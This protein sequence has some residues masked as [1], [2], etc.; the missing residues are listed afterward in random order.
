MQSQ[1]PFAHQPPPPASDGWPAAPAARKGRALAAWLVIVVVCLLTMA[2]HV[3]GPSLVDSADED[4]IG[5][6]IMRMQARYVVGL[7]NSSIFP[8]DGASI[9][10]STRFVLNTGTVGQRQRSVIIAADLAGAAEAREELEALDVLLAAPP[11]GGPVQLTRE[12]VSVQ[13]ILHQLYPDPDGVA[14]AD[15][16]LARSAEMLGPADRA[17]L[18]DELGWFG[19]LA[20]AP[21]GSSDAAAREAVLRPARIVAVVMVSVAVLGVGAVGVGFIGLVLLVVFTLTG[22]LRSGF[23]SPRPHHAVYAETF[24]VWMVLFLGLQLLAKWIATPGTEMSVTVVVF[25]VSLTALIWPVARGIPWPQ[26][27]EDVGWTLG[28]LPWAEPF[29]GVGGYVVS[30]PLVATGLGMTLLLMWM[31]GAVAGEQPTFAPSG[32]PAHPIIV[33]MGGAAVW[34]KIQLLFLAAIV[35]PIVEE[36]MFRGVLYRHLR[37]ASARLGLVASVLVSVV[38]NGFVFAAIHPQGLV[39][40]PALMSLACGMALIREWRGT[41]IPAVVIHGVS[42]GLIMG[43]LMVILS[44]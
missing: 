10:S 16:A 12:Q 25:L 17:L 19:E 36:T 35:A 32:G 14:D 4:P 8:Q 26:V 29:I 44:V 9:Y 5:L 38:I 13:R 39:A 24:A 11:V 20:L 31:Q 28:R 41:L 37:D 42:N 27:R 3:V 43:M 18:T 33:D 40:I 6:T 34:P 7:A 23:G 21:P 1:D 15:G 22:H 2:V 30:L